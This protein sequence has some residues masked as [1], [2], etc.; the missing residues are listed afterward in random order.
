MHLIDTIGKIKRNTSFLLNSLQKL[1]LSSAEPTDFESISQL[2][3]LS[4]SF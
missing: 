3:A 2:Y 4:S 1:Y